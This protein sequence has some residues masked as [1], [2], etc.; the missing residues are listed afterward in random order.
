MRAR[1]QQARRMAPR[2]AP[3]SRFFPLSRA[4]IRRTTVWKK[5]KVIYAV[6]ALVYFIGG[7]VVASRMPY[8][9]DWLLYVVFQAL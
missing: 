5:I 6:G 1:A 2:R 4:A 7:L 9:S 8:F 3:T